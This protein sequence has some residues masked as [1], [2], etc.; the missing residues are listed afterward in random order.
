MMKAIVTLDSLFIH[1]HNVLKD[2]PRY[3]TPVENL[4]LSIRVKFERQDINS[5]IILP[6]VRAAMLGRLLDG[7]CNGSACNG[8][9]KSFLQF[10]AHSNLASVESK[11]KE[12]ICGSCILNCPAF[13]H[14]CATVLN[15]ELVFIQVNI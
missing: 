4:D 2:S 8:F 15:S 7:R 10:N 9:L 14:F 1:L 13:Q 3:P 5:V 11:A 12:H 6:H